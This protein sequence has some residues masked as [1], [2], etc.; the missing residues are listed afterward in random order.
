MTYISKDTAAAISNGN[1]TT[2]VII[3][4]TAKAPWSGKNISGGGGHNSRRR[5]VDTT[6]S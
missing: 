2:N 6:A 4:N 1:T 5:S 3:W